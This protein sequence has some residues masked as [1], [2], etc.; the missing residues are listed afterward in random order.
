MGAAGEAILNQHQQSIPPPQSGIPIGPTQQASGGEFAVGANIAVAEGAAG[1]AAGSFAASAGMQLGQAPVGPPPNVR[2]S[3]VHLSGRPP[4]RPPPPPVI[5]PQ[6][7]GAQPVLQP[8]TFPVPAGPGGPPMVQGG[9]PLIQA[10]APGAGVIPPNAQPILP[11]AVP[12]VAIPAGPSGAVRPDGGLQN[13]F[14]YGPSE[15]MV[16]G[17]VNA[18]FGRESHR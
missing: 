13:V 5:V 3:S 14:P 15:N 9:G 16:A 8:L 1:A 18:L 7:P 11:E 10:P 6:P 12:A 2:P 17:D 4:S